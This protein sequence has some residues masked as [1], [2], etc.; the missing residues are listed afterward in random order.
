MI[1]LLRFLMTFT[2]KQKLQYKT[3]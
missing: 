1:A 3:I 2:K